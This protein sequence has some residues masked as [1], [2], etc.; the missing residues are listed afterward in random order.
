MSTAAVSTI[1]TV[2]PTTKKRLSYFFYFQP[3]SVG[4]FTPPATTQPQQAT[5]LAQ[6]GISLPTL[7]QS[8]THR[9]RT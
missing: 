4:F 9:K 3:T 1:T 7:N 8:H 5:P 6:S 2:F